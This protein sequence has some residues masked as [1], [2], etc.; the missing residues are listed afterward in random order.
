MA[1]FRVDEIVVY[2]DQPSRDQK[3]EI[4]LIATLLSYLETPQ[5]LRR[6]LFRIMPELRYAGTLPPLR[7]LHHPVRNRVSDLR[8]GEYREGVITCIHQ[9]AADVDIGVEKPIPVLG[10]RLPVN[11][12]VTVKITRTGKHPEAILA[13]RYEIETYWGYEVTTSERTF[14]EMLR[15]RSFNLVIATSRRG[16]DFAEIISELKQRWEKSQRILVAFGAP[17]QGLYEIAEQEGAELESIAD[18]VINTIPKQGTE[19]VRT[20]EAIYATL[21]IL[22]VF[23]ESHFATENQ[24]LYI[25]R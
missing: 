14:G 4:Q 23:E 10:L 8:T 12:R 3:R 5:Y 21:S 6:H 2:Q 16:R 11:T 17:T 25:T 9:Q 1:I 20:E 24:A 13:D 7:T 19:T 15:D 18:Y 22:N